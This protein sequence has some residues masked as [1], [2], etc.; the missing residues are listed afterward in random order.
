MRPE[1]LLA[2]HHHLAMATLNLPCRTLVS[3]VRL[4][5]FRCHK[6]FETHTDAANVVLH[7]ANG[8]GKTS[9]LEAISLLASG[10]G[11]R[12]ATSDDI[13]LQHDTKPSNSWSVNATI[14]HDVQLFDAT[15]EWISSSNPDTPN[16]KRVLLDGKKVS[17]FSEITRSFNF[18]WLT[19]EM[20]RILAESPAKRRRLLDQ[21]VCLFDRSHLTR[22]NAY[23]RSLK[24]RSHLLKSDVND[25]YWLLALEEKIVTNGI[26]IIV[27]RQQTAEQLQDASAN[28]DHIFPEFAVTFESDLDIWV[29]GRPALEA[30]DRYRRALITS[31]QRDGDSGG[32]AIGPHRSSFSVRLRASGR[33]AEDCSSGE[34]KT[35]LLSLVLASARIQKARG[36]T[37]PILLL[38]DIAAHLD[39]RNREALFEAVGRLDVQAWYT[40][41]D[42]ST[43]G[44]IQ[45]SADYCVVGS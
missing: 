11:I 45:Q 37:S 7:G 28:P 3:S 4:L 30:E 17:S 18:T 29:S 16:Q 33:R 22:L 43:F 31:R 44:P 15:V 35:L 20:N 38:D 39:K 2:S 24:Q 21:L 6:R 32:A 13:R 41:T 36:K 40:G 14:R 12:N 1:G 8:A 34:Q 10:K 5:N 42:I 9:V 27:A 25:E 19:P 26:A 23:E